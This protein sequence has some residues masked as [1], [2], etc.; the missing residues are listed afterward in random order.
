[1][2]IGI[3]PRPPPIEEILAGIYAQVL[4]LERV[5]VDDS[6][7][8]SG[9]GFAVGDAP[10]RRDQHRPGC[11]IFRCGRCSRRPRWPS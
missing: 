9:W 5:G 1:M 11:R 3:G 2:P 6:F 8:E 4:G 7:F 10:D